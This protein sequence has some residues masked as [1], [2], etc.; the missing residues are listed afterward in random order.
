MTYQA[1]EFLNMRRWVRNPLTS[2]EILKGRSHTNI[3]ECATRCATAAGSP[4]PGAELNLVLGK[5]TA[6]ETKALNAATAGQ[7]AMRLPFAMAPS[8][9]T[10]IGSKVA[11]TSVGT[12]RK[13][14]NEKQKRNQTGWDTNG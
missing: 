2:T 7:N 10:E 13:R 14:R 1:P 11:L 8:P 3:R 4:H 12:N 9:R 6:K 5:A